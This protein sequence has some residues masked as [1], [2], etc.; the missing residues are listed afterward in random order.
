MLPT[1]APITSAIA[2]GSRVSGTLSAGCAGPR[3]ARAGRGRPSRTTVAVSRSRTVA[4]AGSGG[5]QMRDVPAQVAG[6]R[7]ERFRARGEVD[8]RPGGLGGGAAG[9]IA[10]VLG[11]QGHACTRVAG[12]GWRP[13]G[14]MSAVLAGAHR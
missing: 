3:R 8:Q 11:A 10:A 9:G 13:Q 6:G 2:G 4:V 14:W 12:A 5:E 7:V 1:V